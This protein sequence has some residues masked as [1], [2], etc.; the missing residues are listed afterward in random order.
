MITACAVRLSALDVIRTAA[1]VI[2]ARG[3]YQPL[4]RQWE[5]AV[6]TAMDVEAVLFGHELHEP[7]DAVLFARTA[8]EV[9]ATLPA[10]VL[11]WCR[12]GTAEQSDYRAKLARTVR[13][14]HVTSGDIPLLSSAVAAWQREQRRSDRAAQEAADALHSRHQG[15]VKERITRTVTVAA[16]I[17]LPTRTYGYRTQE[18][19][20]IKLRDD[21]GNVY[22][23]TA[24]PKDPATLP[25]PDARIEIKGTVA[26][27]DTYRAT[28]QTY[29]SRCRWK[30]AP[31][32]N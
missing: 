22:V 28:A 16:V 19:Y 30:A 6:P 7:G 4:S 11:E 31:A 24:S 12:T 23:W 9:P 2:T 18:R 26:Q 17:Q 32:S 10:A 29:I 21:E 3:Y 25:S 27:H 15:D 20:L 1:T 13:A 5:K 8:T 14:D